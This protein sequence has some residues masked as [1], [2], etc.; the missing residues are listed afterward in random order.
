MARSWI[1][2][3]GA[4][5]GCEDVGSGDVLTS[6]MWADVSFTADGTGTSQ[7]AAALRVGGGLSNT[8]VDL[9]G[10]D[11]LTATL[12]DETVPMVEEQLGEIHRYVASFDTAPVGEPLIVAFVRTVDG[13][14]P[15]SVAELP[16]EFDLYDPAAATFSR[17]TEDLLLV[18]APSSS[19]T[20]RIE[21]SGDCVFTYV[22]DVTDGGTYTL[23]A[24][25]L[26]PLDDA[27]QGTCALD[28]V[29]RRIQPGTVDPAFGEGGTAFGIQSRQT[30]VASTP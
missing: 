13:G 11:E 29:V 26:D 10:D 15:G 7:A 22:E 3:L 16:P 30:E 17:N 6:G 12:T 19:H 27:N 14:A 2:L 5:V 21:I 25:T 4:L 28:I 1:V 24:G 20:M 18:W 23:P 9:E 8:Y